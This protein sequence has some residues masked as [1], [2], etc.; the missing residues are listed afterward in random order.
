MSRRKVTV[1]KSDFELFFNEIPDECEVYLD[2]DTGDVL[3]VADGFSPEDDERIA[4]LLSDDFFPE[5]DSRYLRVERPFSRDRWEDMADFIRTLAD[6]RL[7]D[8]FWDAI[9]GR[10]AFGRFYAMLARYP[11]T[12]KA[13]DSFQKQRQDERIQRWFDDN[14]LDVT[15][16]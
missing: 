5:E 8:A 4:Y 13:W 15:F 14:D 7:A 11:K 2:L 16:A 1:N 3:M 12:E 6:A 9:Q 10:G